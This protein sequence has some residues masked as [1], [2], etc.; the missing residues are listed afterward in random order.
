MPRILGGLVSAVFA[1]SAL[2]V[3]SAAATDPS[4]RIVSTSP[5]I[6]D[7]LFA[8]GLGPRVVGV[9]N[10]CQY[11]AEVSGLA[12]VG[13][14]LKPDVELIARLH[15]D[16]VVINA[17]PNQ[18]ERQ[19]AT[20]G[21]RSITVSPGSLS[22]VYTTIRTIG[23]AAGV[24]DR[25]EALVAGLQ[26]RLNRVRA[27]ASGGPSP[28]VLVIVGRRT[29]TLADLVAV[30]G[31]SY[32]GELIGVAGGTN[33]LGDDRLPEYPRISMETVIRLAPDVIVDAADMG[34][35]LESRLRK[36]PATLA[37][38]RR[39]TGLAAVQHNEVHLISSDAFLVPGPRVV[40]A[41]EILA[42]WF[43]GAPL[44]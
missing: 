39:E 20:L 29:G 11:P 12:R 2:N 22:N 31:K 3:I 36:Q 16:L 26:Q 17:G 7:S 21:I 23:E 28:K 25:A 34:D 6:T 24:P 15:P 5:S 30:G 42:Q 18:T 41:S 38:W 43:R 33:V 44:R 40:E 13:S 1:L 19:L 37:M 35:A 4:M 14:F 8:L 32:L 27:S 10:F 9:S